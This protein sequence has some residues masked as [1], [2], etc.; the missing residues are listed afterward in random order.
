MSLTGTGLGRI[1][2]DK[3]GPARKNPNLIQLCIKFVAI[4]KLF[5]KAQNKIK[6]RGF[7][8]ISR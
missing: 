7:L 1:G 5:F 6:W 4:F 2:I 3:T 8:V